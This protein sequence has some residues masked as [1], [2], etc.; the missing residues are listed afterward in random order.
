MA[1]FKENKKMRENFFK[2]IKFSL[3][4]SQ[5][6]DLKHLITIIFNNSKKSSLLLQLNMTKIFFSNLK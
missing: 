1:N 5:L 6:E 3:S 2:F 4:F